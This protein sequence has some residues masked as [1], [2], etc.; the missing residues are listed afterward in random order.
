MNNFEDKHPR[1]S[2][3]KFTEKNRKES[4]LTLDLRNSEQWEQVASEMEEEG[5]PREVFDYWTRERG[6]TD[7]E[8]AKEVEYAYY[9]RYDSWRDFVEDRADTVALEE[10]FDYERFAW[11]LRLNCKVEKTGDGVIIHNHN[12][13]FDSEKAVKASSFAE[14]ARDVAY[15]TIIKPE[16]KNKIREY[17][18]YTSLEEDLKGEFYSREA[19][20]GMYVLRDF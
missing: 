20:S 9:G 11:D 15:E 2:D 14:Y 7:P 3:G 5:V 16:D 12:P 1:S 19:G 18:D 13:G 4:G 6:I 17:C 10:H 8:D